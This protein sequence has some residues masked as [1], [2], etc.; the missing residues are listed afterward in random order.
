MRLSNIGSRHSYARLHRRKT[1]RGGDFVELDGP[2]FGCGR[3]DQNAARV[4]ILKARTPTPQAAFPPHVPKINIENNG[5]S[6]DEMEKLGSI[7]RTPTLRVLA[8]QQDLALCFVYVKCWGTNA[9]FLLRD[10]RRVLPPNFTIRVSSIVKD[11][12]WSLHDHL[13]S[14]VSHDRIS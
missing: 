11:T 4:I 2:R 13:L 9:M 14:S 3:A 5:R 10:L 8:A 7:P 6:P 1:L 12:K